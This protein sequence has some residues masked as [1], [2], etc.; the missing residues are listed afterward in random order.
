[1]VLVLCLSGQDRRDSFPRL[2][3]TTYLD[4]SSNTSELARA[5]SHDLGILHERVIDS[6]FHVHW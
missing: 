4:S 2:R 1:M 5:L 3:R 6:C